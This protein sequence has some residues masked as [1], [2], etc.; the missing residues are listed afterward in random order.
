MHSTQ[1]ATVTINAA[2]LQEIKE[3]NRELRQV[4]HKIAT[5]A[6]RPRLAVRPR[7]LVGLLQQLRDQ[8]AMHFALEEA[9]G[10]FEDAVSV[11]PWLCC[12]AEELRGQHTELFL[13]ICG[14]VDEAEEL[15]YHDAPANL[16]RRLARQF[17][18]WHSR[19]LDH[20]VRE[21]N[22]VLAAFDDDIGVGD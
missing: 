16:L 22:L 8:L 7:H 12:A 15:L 13:D 11:A 17:V 10:Y 3:D 9:Y 21:T 1:T 14:I 19:F 4:L 2:F 5:I 18:E 6:S 20:E